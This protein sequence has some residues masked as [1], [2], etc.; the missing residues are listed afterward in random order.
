M[1]FCDH[2]QVSNFKVSQESL[3]AAFG[4]SVSPALATITFWFRESGR[5]N[6]SDDPRVGRP[7]TAITH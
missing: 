1:I 6:S 5:E 3:Q 4:E 2:K 7:P